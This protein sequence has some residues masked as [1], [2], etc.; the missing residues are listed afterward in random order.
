MTKNS[1]YIGMDVHQKTIDIT[2]AEEGVTAESGASA[3]SAAI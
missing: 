3:P 1:M 2:V